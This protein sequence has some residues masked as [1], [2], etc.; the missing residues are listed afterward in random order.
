[1]P[2]ELVCLVALPT[3]F[4]LSEIESVLLE[5]LLCVLDSIGLESVFLLVSM[6]F[7]LLLESVLLES[8]LILLS[9]DSALL[10]SAKLVD[11]AL[12]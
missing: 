1:M 2:I 4:L 11:S 6:L 3:L 12:L 8:L 10:E 9:L 7:G 5:S